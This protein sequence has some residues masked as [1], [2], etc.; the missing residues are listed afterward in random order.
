MSVR[1]TKPSVAPAPGPRGRAPVRL[2][3]AVTALEREREQLRKEL[4]EAHARIAE[5]EK[6]R[7]DALDR[8]DW[9]IDSL[10]TYIQR[11]E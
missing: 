3:D 8:I 9:A 7:K 2:A 10:H 4:A 6:A 11:A 5:L 1:K